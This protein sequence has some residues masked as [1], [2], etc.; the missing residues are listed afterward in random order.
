MSVKKPKK[1]P[2]NSSRGPRPNTSAGSASPDSA[3]ATRRALLATA[4]SCFAT[5]GYGQTGTEE[6]VQKADVTRGALY[7]H[8]KDKRALFAAVVEEVE[9]ELS[10]G[11]Q[12]LVANEP[13][14]LKALALGATSFLEACRDPAVR[15]IL[16]IDAPSVLGWA[17]WREI[18]LRYG[19]GML[20]D[21]LELGMKTGLLKEQP[22]G[23]L[24]HLV[25]GAL[26]EAG[27]LVA[28][29]DPSTAEGQRLLEETERACLLLLDGLKTA[30]A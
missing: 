17:Q 9:S 19:L 5:K 28:H 3:A 16:M 20:R 10:A 26:T 8:F 12:A 18:D 4:R 21:Q 11:L 29:A 22:V 6:L 2:P 30:P 13:D 7:H 25:L 14:I 15:R 1:A 24:A 23:P 27:M